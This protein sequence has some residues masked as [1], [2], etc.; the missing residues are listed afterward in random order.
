MYN[1]TLA[2]RDA[3]LAHVKF[4]IKQDTLAAL[5]QAPLEAATLFLNA[6]LKKAEEDILKFEDRGRSHTSSA[7]RKDNRYHPYKRSD[8]AYPDS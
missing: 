8:K 3:Y 7:I 5:H 6:I 4:G 1:F 2:R